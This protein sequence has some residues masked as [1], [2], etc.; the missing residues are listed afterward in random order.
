MYTA[1]ELKDLTLKPK[2]N[3]ITLKVLAD[4]YGMFLNP[5]V[6]KY[7]VRD[8]KGT[9][10]IEL[11]FKYE[12]FCHLLGIENIAK[13]SVPYKDLHEYRGLDGWNNIYGNNASG[14]VLDIP[15]LK[16]INKKKF[17][18]VKAKFVYFYL[19]PNLI[20]RPLSVRYK[21]ENVNPPTRIDCEIMFYSMVENDNAIIH[22][23]IKKVE[24]LGYYIP[25]T[26]FVEKV[27][28]KQDDIYLAQQEEIETKTY[29]IQKRR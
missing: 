16:G 24:K 22:L 18:S 6:Y 27:S 23:G 25:K 15:L 19:L 11:R 10:N 21:N 8:I 29:T 13:Y 4:Y 1:I 7:I 14:F 9:Q 17:Q 28:E 12:N 20:E 3:D 26:F 2:I 5:F